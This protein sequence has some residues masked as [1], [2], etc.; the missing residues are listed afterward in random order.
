V[1]NPYF[2]EWSHAAR[3]N[4]YPAQIVWRIGASP[5]TALTAVERG[6]A[7]YTIDGPPADRLSEVQTR[8]ASQ[9]NPDP[10]D[11]TAALWFNTGVAPFNDLRVRQ[12]LNYAIDRV[13]AARL[14]GLEARPTC[15]LL[16][17]YVPG[18]QPYCPYTVDR[19]RGGSWSASDLGKAR[20]LIA[21]SHTRGMHVNVTISTGLT[22]GVD[23]TAVGRY[24]ARLLDN[25]GYRTRVT[26]SAGLVPG[27]SKW[28]A[29]FATAAPAYAAASEFIQFWLSC[30]YISGGSNIS[31]FCDRGVES[32]MN[33][34]FAAEAADGFDSPA[35]A[36]L[37]ASA[38]R[39]VTDAAPLVPLANPWALDF[40]SPRVGN[41]QYNP[42]Q[43]IL[44]D[45]LWV[46]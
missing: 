36:R 26:T 37:W 20:E 1:R 39:Q 10:N 46:K 9:L 40:V 30:R 6:R 19:N 23:Y 13:K 15:Q 12:A 32:T 27:S 28:Q 41:Y 24:V 31:A 34:A 42:E 45:Q 17:P 25:L 29:A 5:S 18:Y 4:G 22:L 33:S 14:I 8:F 21:A 38:D 11:I 2:R 35:A 16:P 44:L 43:G 3:P 7:D